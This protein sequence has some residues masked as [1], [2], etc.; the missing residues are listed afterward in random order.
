MTGSQRISIL[1]KDFRYAWIDSAVAQALGKDDRRRIVCSRCIDSAKED[2]LDIICLLAQVRGNTNLTN[3]PAG[4]R[5]ER[6][7]FIAL[8]QCSTATEVAV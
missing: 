1:V 6:S 8:R 4:I 7:G 3:V 2:L 5:R